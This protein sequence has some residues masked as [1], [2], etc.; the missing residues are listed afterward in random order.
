MTEKQK[1]TGHGNADGSRR[2]IHAEIPVPM[3]TFDQAH[4]LGRVRAM[5]STATPV[6]DE[7]IVDQV[8]AGDIPRF[9]VLMRRHNTAVHRAVRG[10]LPVEADVEEVMQEAYLAVYRNLGKFERRASF[11]TWLIRI[12]VH[13]ALARAR[14]AKIAPEV[15]DERAFDGFAD[16]APSA[17]RLA[18]A[19]QAREVLEAE[20]D[21]LPPAFRLVFV[22]REVE[23]LDPA[24]VS[25]MLG[26][27]PETV[28]TR[29]H[30]ARE[31]L[32]T[33]LEARFTD[34]MSD[35]LSFHEARCCRVVY[36]VMRAID[37]TL[38]SA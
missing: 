3:L 12:A 19:S 1:T 36:A 27:S 25:D 34:A 14:R 4:D 38:Q 21:R 20:I 11:R 35:V 10:V 13:T 15:H 29:H 2:S 18:D 30:R 8:L 22:L 24:D 32:R 17:D 9:E 26:V 33:A 6:P 37:D 31:R 16:P 5:V 23:G 7:T 28:R